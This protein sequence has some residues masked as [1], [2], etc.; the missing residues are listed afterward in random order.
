MNPVQ[1]K[2]VRVTSPAAIVDNASLTCQVVDRQGFDFARYVFYFGAMDIAATALKVQESD[3]TSSATAL[4]SG[5]D[6]TGAVYGTSTNDAGSTSALPTATDDNKFF[7]IEI[8]LKGRK[9][10]LNP[11]VTL[12]DGAAGTYVCAWCELY[13]GEQVPTTAAQK[14]A[15]Q[16]LRVP[17]L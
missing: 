14:G 1:H 9:R 10:Y 6:I 5:A 2:L 3:T 16:N 7:T 15:A 13:R 11:V 8:D 4:S 17:A 12:G